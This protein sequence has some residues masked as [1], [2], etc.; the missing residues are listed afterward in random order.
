MVDEKGTSNKVTTGDISEVS[1]GQ[2]NAAGRDVVHVTNTY[3][4]PGDLLRDY[5]DQVI[6]MLQRAPLDETREGSLKILR[7]RTLTTLRM[8]PPERKGPLVFFLIDAELITHVSLQ[9][10]DLRNID[11]SGAELDE[12]D[13]Q[14]ADLSGA[15]LP[16][17]DLSG[18]NLS[19]ADLSGATL[20]EAYL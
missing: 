14:G 1:G 5:T 8:L 18:A 6:S 13:L 12:A 9:Q 15:N 11:L 10:T 16:W 19:W 20:R 7:L 2:V 4:Q 17:A 3:G